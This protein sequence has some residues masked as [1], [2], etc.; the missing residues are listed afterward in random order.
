MYI[1]S[2]RF[3]L[4]NMVIKPSDPDA[5]LLFE[6]QQKNKWDG[7]NWFPE[8]LNSIYLSPEFEFEGKAFKITNQTFISE[9][10]INDLE[11]ST[12][13]NIYSWDTVAESKHASRVEP[14]TEQLQLWITASV[15]PPEARTAQAGY[16][17]NNS[18]EQ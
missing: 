6:L 9:V 14:G 5:N 15:Q 4:E 17:G 18:H 3:A 13:L 8:Q 7:K 2:I 16:Y 11:K 1:S 10:S 12:K